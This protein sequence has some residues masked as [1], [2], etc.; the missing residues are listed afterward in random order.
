MGC[1]S[2]NAALVMTTERGGDAVRRISTRRAVR[3][4]LGAAG[5]FRDGVF[6]H[7]ERQRV[8]QR[9]T[10][11]EPVADNPTGFE[12]DCVRDLRGVHRVLNPR[13][14]AGVDDCCAQLLETAV[15]ADW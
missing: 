7:R 15:A 13:P 9:V 14:A 12:H 4:G 1:R 8:G 2:G 6:E 5:R 11:R 3:G 10:G